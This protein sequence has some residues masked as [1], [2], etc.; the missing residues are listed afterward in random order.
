M[1][2][3]FKEKAV[4]EG[5][6]TKKGCQWTLRSKRR[7]GHKASK[8]KVTPTWI[9]KNFEGPIIS[10][11]VVGEGEKKKDPSAYIMLDMNILEGSSNDK[12]DP[13]G[14]SS[15]KVVSPSSESSMAPI[16][17]IGHDDKLE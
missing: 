10:I 17:M 13:L 8:F 7:T 6:S 12:L 9:P 15:E 4:H 2:E 5:T 16:Y 14:A 3:K 1:I 11:N